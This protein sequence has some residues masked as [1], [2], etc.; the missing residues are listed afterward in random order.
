M[1]GE[2]ELVYDSTQETKTQTA[3]KVTLNDENT[4]GK[5]KKITTFYKGDLNIENNSDLKVGYARVEGNTTLKNSKASFTNSLMIGNITQ[6]KSD[7]TINEVTLIGNLDLYNGS[8]SAVSDS[9]VEGNIKLGNSHL[10][11]KDSQINGKISATEGKLNLYSTVWTITEDS[12]VDT[13]L[14]GG[15]SQIKFNTR[16]V[17]RSARVRGR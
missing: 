13:L 8:N 6:D 11:L 12:Q 15:D 10:V 16:S 1:D 3:T 2:S 5:F 9:V 14:I 17:A 7:S 4:N